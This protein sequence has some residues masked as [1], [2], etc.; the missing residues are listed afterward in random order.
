[1]VIDMNPTIEI[2]ISD[3]TIVYEI[4][5]DNLSVV[6]IKGEDIAEDNTIEDAVQMLNTP[7]S[8]NGYSFKV[9]HDYKLKLWV[10]IRTVIVYDTI[11]AVLN[12]YANDPQTA[13]KRNEMFFDKLQ[14][15]YNPNNNFF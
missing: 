2:N 6:L 12:T 1:M 15:Y 14:R 3:S 11:D 8:D 9:K 4:D 5:Q 13:F 10:C 7:W